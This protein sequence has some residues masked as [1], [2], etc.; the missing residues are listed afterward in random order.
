MR[1]AFLCVVLV[2]AC[3]SSAFGEATEELLK[4]ARD[5]K[6]TPRMI[7]NLIKFGADVNARDAYGNTALMLTSYINANPEV[8]NA[9]IKAGANINAKN[10]Q[11]ITAL[12]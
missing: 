7:E 4:V 9:L 11:G 3:V 2:M 10:N 1:K 5:K 6:T 8:V 12:M